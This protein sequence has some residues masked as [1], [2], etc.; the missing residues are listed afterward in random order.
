[1]IFFQSY[2]ARILFCIWR[3]SR[4]REMV[5]KAVCDIFILFVIHKS[6]DKKFFCSRLLVGNMRW[7]LRTK[8]NLMF[9]SE[10]EKLIMQISMPK[11]SLSCFALFYWVQWLQHT[12]DDR[13][14][15]NQ[16][17]IWLVNDQKWCSSCTLGYN[18]LHRSK[19]HV[20]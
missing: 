17:L 2:V 12:L 15:C 7:W 16:C 8:N 13:T 3:L 19:W 9:V 5:A 11:I 10:T 6:V 1:M 18:I 4:W 20:I 14:R